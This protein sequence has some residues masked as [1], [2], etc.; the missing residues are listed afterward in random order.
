ML[1]ILSFSFLGLLLVNYAIRPY[2]KLNKN[3]PNSDDIIRVYLN[4]DFKKARYIAS[5]TPKEPNS[6]LVK[7][8]IDIYSNESPNIHS[9]L[10]E[11]R[12]IYENEKYPSRIRTQAGITYARHIQVYRARKMYP[13]YS[14]IDFQSVYKNVIAKLAPD[15]DLACQSACYLAESYFDNHDFQKQ[16]QLF[17]FIEQFTNNFQ[18]NPK[19]L[20]A[21][22][23]IADKFYI[24][25]WDDYENSTRHLIRAYE[26]GITKDILAKDSLFRIARISEVK[27]KN[28][29]QAK[30]YYEL[31]LNS[32][33]NS[34]LAPLAKRYLNELEK[35]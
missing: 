16:Q 7:A 24:E 15:S 30:R 11:L 5:I 17:K 6:I 14:E 1:I 31:F 29:L 25:L 9:G 26:T 21:V 13:V 4:H 35:R 20:V 3:D 34:D 23:V 8:L 22:H 33:P 27:L 12:V 19:D 2:F 10:D 32:Y 28:N 18:G